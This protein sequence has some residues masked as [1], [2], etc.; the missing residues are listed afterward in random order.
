MSVSETILEEAARIVAGDR[1]K[2]YGDIREC[3]IHISELWSA[4]LGKQISIF[5]VA[6]M[7]MLLKISRNRHDIKRDGLVDI[8]GYA[9]CAELLLGNAVD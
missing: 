4:Y 2:E 5:D 7:M 8:A 1:Q 3:F 6:H 9:R